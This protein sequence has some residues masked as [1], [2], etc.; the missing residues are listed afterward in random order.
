[1]SSQSN[2][3]KFWLGDSFFDDDI[4]DG[5][6]DVEIKSAD[7]MKLVSYKR[8]IGNFV[9]ILTNKPIPVTFSDG[10]DSYTDGSEVVIS[11]KMDDKDFDPAVG[12]ALHEGSHILLTDFESI[13]KIRAAEFP[14]SIDALKLYEKYGADWDVKSQIK[15]NLFNLLN[16][17]EDRRIDNYVFTSS[18][19]YRGYYESMYNKYFNSPN[20]AKGLTSSEYRTEDWESYFF[21]VIN[22]TN[23]NRD[24]T[25]LKGL[26]EIWKVLDLRNIQRLTS[27][28]DAMEVAGELFMIIDS[29]IPYVTQPQQSQNGDGNPDN[30]CNDGNGQTEM[31]GDSSEQATGD[32]SPMGGSGS[33]ISSDSNSGNSDSNSTSGESDGGEPT[34]VPN[35]NGAGGSLGNGSGKLTDRQKK[36]LDSA[37]QKQK[38]FQNGNIS[39]KKIKKVEKQKIDALDKADMTSEV[40][41]K[42]VD[43]NQYW[44]KNSNGIQTY[45]INNMTKQLIDSNLIGMLSSRSWVAERND[46]NIQRGI[47]IGTQLGRKLKTRNEE[48]VTTTPRMKSGKLSGRMI[49]EIGFGNF[50]IFE[51]KLVNKSNPV[52]LHI[53]VDASSSMSGSKWNETQ[54]AV[55]AIAKAASMTSN[56]NVVISYRSVYYSRGS[57]NNSQPLMLIAYDSRKDK[58]SK[59]K[60]L[61]KY[62]ECD[63]TTPE[64]LCYEAVMNDIIKSSKGVES[65]LINFSDGMPGFDSQNF[66]Y[67]GD[68]AIKHTAAQIK[69]IKSC[70]INV[71]SY[72][73][74]DGGSYLK[75]SFTN[76]Y[77]KD[78]EFIDVNNVSQL[79]R[80]LNKKFEVRN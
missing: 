60:N 80:T 8:S 71:L 73:V 49:H 74:G 57:W 17:V 70:G 67:G 6:S 55:V 51:Q 23:E 3:S 39:K 33:G 47:M 45:V 76:M 34:S 65:Y 72:F 40:V 30:D 79:A 69:K 38:D 19:G 78:S 4:K 14:K 54:T 32:G 52:L 58:F 64:G 59:I 56:I 1:M 13:K 50:D 31:S 21:R 9:K 2:Y 27:T 7:I 22:I 42:G 41:G 66:S 29:Y 46:R 16:Y 53:S 15:E 18:P 48:R 75:Q 37:I 24:L 36:M 26:K 68:E 43:S 11:S 25:A 20:I 63:A 28:D 77:G 12:L 61:F 62:I 5:M 10:N 44:R 35:Q